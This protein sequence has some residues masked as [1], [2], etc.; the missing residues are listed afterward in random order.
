ML[1]DRLL[2]LFRRAMGTQQ[3]LELMRSSRLGSGQDDGLTLLEGTQY[4][5]YAVPIEYLPS[6]DFRPRYGHTHP[7]IRSLEEWFASCAGEYRGFIGQ[8]RALDVSHIAASSSS[9][10]AARPAWIGGAICAFDA[11][12]LYA[13]VRKHRPARYLEIGSGM[14]TCFARQAVVD[15]G[16]PT[17]II[18]IDPEPRG[19]ID[20]ICDEVVRAGLETCDLGLFDGLAAGDVVFFDGSHR[21]FMNSD[22]TVFFIDVLPRLK[23][24]VI[25]HVHDICLPYDY[26][27]VYRKWY[28]NEQYLLAVYMMGNR[29]RIRPLLPT[30]FI[31]KSPLFEEDLRAPFADLGPDNG[32]WRGGGSMWFTHL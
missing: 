20:G 1:R 18:S 14:T 13:M 16:L 27:E 22:V 32:S 2:K 17:R 8:M 26:P 25:V 24:G 28:W 30:A 5:R 7:P 6:R 12:A 31:C 19:E 29:A 21:A 11:L 15:A 4:A 9:A 23:P 10:R 3:I